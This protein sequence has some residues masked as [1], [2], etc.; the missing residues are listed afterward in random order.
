MWLHEKADV[1]INLT[2]Q[3]VQHSY[4]DVDDVLAVGA[5]QMR[6]CGGALGGGRGD[7]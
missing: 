7:Y 6:M 3:G 2:D 1:L 4:R 5:L